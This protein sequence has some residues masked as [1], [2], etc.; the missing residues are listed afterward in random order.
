MWHARKVST[1]LDKK[2]IPEGPYVKLPF[3]IVLLL[4]KIRRGMKSI[5]ICPRNRMN[6]LEKINNSEH[7]HSCYMKK[8]S[9]DG[10]KSKIK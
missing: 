7:Y 6:L 10:L 1:V 2:Y 9:R 3:F 8:P 5:S 4:L